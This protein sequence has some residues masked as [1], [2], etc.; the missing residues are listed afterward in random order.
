MEK[1]EIWK[2]IT[3]PEYSKFYKVSTKGSI[4]NIKTQKIISQHIRNGYKAVCLYSP[5]TKKKNTYNVHRLVSEAF[6]PII[7]NKLFINH[8]DGNKSNNILE[9]L[10]WVS[11]KENSKH[12]LETKLHK[13]HPKAVKQ[14]SMNNMYIATFNSIIEAAKKTGCNDRRISCVCKGKQ[15]STGGYKWS[16]VIEEDIINLE[17][18]EGKEINGY[19][20]YIITKDG[21]IYSKRAKKFLKPKKLPSGYLCVKLCNNR[22]QVDAYINKLIKEYYHD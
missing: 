3:K 19:P 6:I 7:D 13:T 16:Y 14:F 11:P 17:N 12:A 20:N 10:E 9:N 5:D 18:I 1:E 2:Y 21:N 15:I 8:K 4:K 22:K